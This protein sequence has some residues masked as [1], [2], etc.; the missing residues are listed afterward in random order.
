M[1]SVDHPEW[2]WGLLLLPVLMLWSRSRLMSEPRRTLLA[3]GLRSLA[4]T[5]VL[6]AAADVHRVQRSDNVATIVILDRTQSIPE[7][8]QQAALDALVLAASNDPERQP[9]DRLGVIA[10]GA[11]PAILEM[12]V[13]GGQV[14]V[15]LEPTRRDATD[16]GA[17]VATALSILPDDARARLVL[18]SDGVD[19]EGNFGESVARSSAAGIPID[20]YPIRHQRNAEVR[21]ESV[22]APTKVRPGQRSP[23][24]IAVLAQKPTA[25][26]LRLFRSGIEIDLDP[27]APGLGLSVQLPEGRSVWET[28][29][30]FEGGGTVSWR[31]VFEPSSSQS[32]DRPENNVGT[33]LTFVEGE[34]RVLL[35]ETSRDGAGPLAEALRASGLQVFQQSPEAAG[36]DLASFAG[37]DL[38]ILSNVPRWAFTDAQ[39]AALSRAVT[40]LGV[41]L[42]T[43]GGNRSFGAGGWLGSELADVFPLDCQPPQTKE[44]PGGAIAMVMHSCEM[45]EGN[46]W[47]RRVAEAAIET[48][49]PNDFVGMVEFDWDAF[50][51]D[52]ENSGCVW[53][54]PM[55]R[56]GDRKSAFAA[57]AALT[58]GDMPDFDPSMELAIAGLAETPVAMRQIIVISDGDPSP[59]TQRTIAEANANR[60][61][62]TTVMVGGH[63]SRQDQVAMEATA[64]ATGG[65]FFKVD[66]PQ[67]LPA[68]FIREARRISRSLIQEGLSVTPSM[69]RGLVGGPLDG[70]SSLPPVRGWVLTGTRGGTASLGSG[71]DTG[72]DEP[73]PLV[74]WWAAGAGRSV[75]VTT[76]A[77]RVWAN[78][79]VNW[80]EYD[81]FWEQ[82]ARWAMRPGQSREIALRTDRKGERAVVEIEAVDDNP[83]ALLRRF[84][85]VAVGPQGQRISL[86]LRQVGPRRWRGEFPLRDEGSW[87]VSAAGRRPGESS[88]DRVLGAIDMPYPEEFRALQDNTAVLE[89]AA[90]Q[91]SGRVLTGSESLFTRDGLSRRQ[92]RLPVWDV[93]LILAAVVF[94]FDVAVRRLALD[95]SSLLRRDVVE[96]PET[97]LAGR[98]ATR[99]QGE[100][101][102]K[103]ATRSG[104]CSRTGRRGAG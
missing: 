20:V 7:A 4:W 21:V 60:V 68:I 99:D 11:D 37:F 78:D 66:D 79:W 88:V 15:P 104:G 52:D 6:L 92:A 5:L 41:G 18:A 67:N 89:R 25:G 94:L 90:R 77:G 70:L 48:L 51:G 22:A 47:G 76:D 63:G 49:H 55:Q 74:A 82:L 13:V 56:V 65:R 32:L 81:R 71:L 93:A 24:R 53:V 57:T 69:Q 72:E 87:F 40:E 16:L 62:I 35:I 10:V 102:A 17:A 19:T 30:N 3:L 39:D 1:I 34:G 86:K 45:P 23:V 83:A 54:L 96:A 38:V 101:V 80:P 50:R 29:Q 97:T 28:P 12:P 46:Y 43:V 14:R 9:E 84:E 103:A 98:V 44:L 26:V 31:A 36:S 73:D 2:L 8:E 42:L 58:Y 85:A 33:A 75:A 91:T 64:I 61:Q 95:W 100:R 27:S 59:P